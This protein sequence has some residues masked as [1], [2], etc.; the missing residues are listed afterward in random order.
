MRRW[1]WLALV[2]AAGVLASAAAAF[3]ATAH[4]TA[5][6]TLVVD[7]SFTIKTS[8]PQRAFDPT[9][10]LIDRALYDT[11]FTYKGGDLS[12]PI[13]LLVSSWKASNGAKTFTFQLKK[14]VHFA[15]GTPLTSKDVV[16]SFERLVNIKGNPA[17]LLAGVT[18]KATGPYTVVMTSTT[19]DT[20]LPAILANPSTGIVNSKLVMAHGGTDAANASTADKAENWLNTPASA[21][22]GSGPY[23]LK[24]YSTTS[25]IVLA[26]NT[27]Y[28]GP[29]KPA[30]STVVVRNMIATTQLINVQ[31]GTHEIAIDLSADQA[32]TLKGNKKLNV[33]LQ[34]STW[35]FWLFANNDPKV[36]TVTSN[37]QWQQAV[38]YGLDYKSILSVAGPGAIQAPGLIPSMFLGSLP[39][40]DD[41]V[42]NVA[43]AKAALAASGL[44]GQQVTLQYPSDLT[45]NGVPF[46][47]MAEKVQANLQ[48]IGFNI[49][50]SGSPTSNWLTTYR[51]GQMAF[52]LS[53]WGPDY[54]D[55]AD[56]LTFA[57]GQLVGLRAGWAKGADPAIEKLAAKALVTTN[58]AQRKAIYQQYQHD[59]NESGP[60]FPL[61][62]PT[63]VFVSTSDLK[64]AVYNAEYDVDVTQ[65]SPK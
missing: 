16:F 20:E 59:L 22:A 21:G 23:V 11:L 44:G 64:G 52:G 35:V 6:S 51:N 17:F 18:V 31:R 7:N 28:W 37:E 49:Q 55:P 39:Q 65:I 26:P 60:Y 29:K 33:S 62:Q 54:P 4:S 48:A 40:K 53:L 10:S 61:M 15:D 14:N 19:P 12:N 27:K 3:G 24:S 41:A 25:Q 43:K 34:P 32:Q 36:S 42:Q 56:Y 5:G 57:P 9:G 30:F 45:I 2:A 38:R 1:K 50:L 63:Q 58:A 13:P 47:T 46:T 8:D